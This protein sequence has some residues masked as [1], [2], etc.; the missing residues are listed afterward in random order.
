MKTLKKKIIA[1]TSR[2][3]KEYGI[4]AVRM[5]YIA[6]NLSI[7][8]RTLYELYTSK[9]NLIYNCLLTYQSRTINMFQ[10]IRL[11]FQFVIRYFWAIV[12]S[13]IENLYK[14]KSVFWLDVSRSSEYKYIYD[15]FSRIWSEELKNIIA[16]CQEEKLVIP[17]LRAD[18]FAEF[19]TALLYNSR[20]AEC[21]PSMLYKSAFFMVRGI[22]TQSGIDKFD[23]ISLEE[24]TVLRGF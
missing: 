20:V 12:K 21:T 11:N 22:L 18:L 5:D 19:L 9:E 16:V 10:I 14:A 2:S 24:T 1:F 6:R 15:S 8:K 13:Y 7:S 4:H 17:N 3:L 23:Y